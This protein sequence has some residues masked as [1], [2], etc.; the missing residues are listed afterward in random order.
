M[1]SLALSLAVVTGLSLGVTG[2]RIHAH[3]EARGDDKNVQIETPFGGVHVNTNQTTAGDLGLPLYPGAVP[4]KDDEHHESA[5]VHLGFGEWQLRVKVVSYEAPDTQ[6]K[7]MAFYRQAMSRYGTVI[8]CNGGQPVGEPTTTNEGLSCGDDSQ[9][10]HFHSD[11]K[12]SKLSYE[13]DGKKD[14]GNEIGD[15]QL[16]VGSKR[17]QHIVGFEKPGGART[18]FTIISLDLPREEGGD[19]G[20]KD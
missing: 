11:K 17:H 20:A 8:T 2:C 18:R 12:N 6:D 14:L 15:L 7:V 4:S 1:R 3:N 19:K 9:K 5:D 16:R 13:S 10:F